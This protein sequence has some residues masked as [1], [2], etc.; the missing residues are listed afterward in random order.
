MKIKQQKSKY[1]AVNILLALSATAAVSNA[2]LTA[3]NLSFEDDGNRN[4]AVGA[5]GATGWT[6]LTDTGG[7]L[8]AGDFR[9]FPV[10]GGNAYPD[11]TT[12]LL[13]LDSRD[14]TETGVLAQQLSG[15]AQA[16]T[17]TFSVADVGVANFGDNNNRVITYG[18]SLNGVNFISGSSQTLTE[19]TE[20]FSPDNNATGQFSGSVSYTADGTEAQLWLALSMDSSS[21]VRS[22]ATI[23]ST[24]LSF[25]AIPEPS[26]TAL[27]GLGGLALILRRRRR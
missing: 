23:G 5:T 14:A 18:F 11:S 8:D 20:I 16:G 26:S 12:I 21:A 2:A 3:V 22:T 4:Y 6:L 17:Y 10:S 25:V 24:D 15:T 9:T 19:G 7:G 1:L 27:L 13:L